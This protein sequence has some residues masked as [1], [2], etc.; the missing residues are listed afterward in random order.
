MF[1]EI[2]KNVYFI[3]DIII[4]IVTKQE[5]IKYWVDS[6]ESDYRT[7]HN[8]YQSK[9]YM[10]ALFLG[11][12]AIEKLLKGLAIQ[13]NVQNIPKLHDLNKLS[14]IAGLDIEESLKD[15]LDKITLFNIE[16]RYP[17]YKNEFYKKCNAEF[18][19][20]NI[21]EISDIRIWLIGQLKTQVE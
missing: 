16:T 13:N 19:L 7:M 12:L 18:C 20:K 9:D 21:N 4:N 2:R 1:E 14:K 3:C 17:D 10:W 8:L 5:L 15:T 6:S 11:H